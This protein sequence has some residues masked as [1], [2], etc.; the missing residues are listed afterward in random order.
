MKKWKRGRHSRPKC[1]RSY[2]LASVVRALR[3]GCGA[4]VSARP[5]ARGRAMQTGHFAAARAGWTRSRHLTAHGIL[6]AWRIYWG[7]MAKAAAAAALM[8]AE[9]QR[10]AK[11]LWFS[12]L[13]KNR[14]E[15][16]RV[17]EECVGTG[18]SL[19]WPDH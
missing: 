1:R 15:E 12:R 10:I 13:A 2:R 18:R 17:G 8:G 14:T 16:R 4:P 5:S 11:Y 3:S 6:R 19:W 7:S 9:V